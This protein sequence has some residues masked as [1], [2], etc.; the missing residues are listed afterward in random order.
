MYLTCVY[1]SSIYA[2]D[3]GRGDLV[4]AEAADAGADG[5]CRCYLVLVFGRLPL[6]LRPV[7][8]C[9]ANTHL[10]VQHTRTGE[11]LSEV[12]EDDARHGVCFVRR[13]ISGAC[14]TALTL[15]AP[16]PS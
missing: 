13:R 16:T 11:P 9:R 14:W 10:D 4:G 15:A 8:R 12:L 2:H 1:L 5:A 7:W 3:K 6:L